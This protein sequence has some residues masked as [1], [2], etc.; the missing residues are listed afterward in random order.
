MLRNLL[1]LR[2]KVINEIHPN[3][4]YSYSTLNV[5]MKH[6]LTVSAL[7]YLYQKLLISIKQAPEFCQSTMI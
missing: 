7:H 4:K 1:A 6:L 3:T 5:I 2:K